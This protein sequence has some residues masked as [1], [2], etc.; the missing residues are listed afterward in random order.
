MDSSSF[1]DRK[2]VLTYTEGKQQEEYNG[3]PHLQGCLA[4][5]LLFRGAC[6]TVEC[7]LVSPSDPLQHTYKEKKVIDLYRKATLEVFY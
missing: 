4:R 3:S 6:S 7:F 2:S 5:R 1:Q